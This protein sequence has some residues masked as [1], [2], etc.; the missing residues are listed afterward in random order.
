MGTEISLEQFDLIISAK[1]SCLV[2]NSRQSRRPCARD[3]WIQA[4]SRAVASLQSDQSVFLTSIGQNTWEIILHLVNRVGGRQIVVLPRQL[5]EYGFS[6]QE[7]VIAAFHL[8][9]DRTSIFTLDC[10]DPALWQNI[11]DAFLVSHAGVLAP[12]SVRSDGNMARLLAANSAKVNASFRIGYPKTIDTIHY[13]WNAA[14]LNPGVVG[15][16]DFLTH[17]TR[18]AQ[19]PFPGQDQFD[20]YEAIL[21]SQDYPGSA[22]HALRRILDEVRIR[23]S[24]RFIRGAFPVVSFAAL[25]PND[26]LRLMRWRRRY[27]YYS[28]EPYGIAIR[29][30][31]AAES[32]FREVRYGMEEDYEV[33]NAEDRPF[34]QKARSEVADWR[35]EAEWRHLGDLDLNLVPVEHLRVIT[36]RP[37]EA[38]LL[39]ETYPY[40]V[41]SILDG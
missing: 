8:N 41:F 15:E 2:L 23:S 26:A 4:T 25:P 24:D 6:S 11:R 27:G 17:W 30:S 5:D 28:F 3:P 10:A 7:A 39:R 20:Y 12:V 37:A 21:N 33:M 13:D 14:K 29:K 31:F 34:F 22:F 19:G 9:T 18:S 16:W 32:G 38:E 35:P 36:Y 1:K 40:E